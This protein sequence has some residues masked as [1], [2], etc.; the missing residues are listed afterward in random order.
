MN[1]HE[2]LKKAEVIRGSS[3]R[4]FGLV[5]AAFFTLFGLTPLRHHH[6]MRVW[7]LVL[8]GIF[9]LIAM[10]RPSVLRTF[11][12]AW[13][14]LGLLMGRV[15]NPVVTTIMFYVVFTPAAVLLRMLGKDPLRLKLAPDAETYWIARTPPGPEAES[16]SMQF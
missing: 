9:L 7:A 10:V 11:N 13:A 6:P 12:K 16:M 5:F 8:A 2:D 15:M 3:D 4:T 14:K 1:F